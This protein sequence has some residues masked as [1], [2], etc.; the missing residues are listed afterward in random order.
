MKKLLI[1]AIFTIAVIGAIWFVYKSQSADDSSD[2]IVSAIE[3]VRGDAYVGYII[4]EQPVEGG[5]VVFFLRNATGNKAAS[6]VS[7]EYVKKTSSG[8]KWGY[9]GSFSAS[10]L[11]MTLPE[12]QAR[13]N[14][15]PIGNA[16]MYVPST[17]G[18]EFGDSPFPMLVGVV[19]HPDEVRVVVKDGVKGLERQ[20]ELIKVSDSFKLYYSFLD[21]VQ[22]QQLY[23]TTYNDNGDIVRED[24]IDETV[25]ITTTTNPE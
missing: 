24:I 8:W 16:S 1:S 18:S 22:G 21:E 10:N 19:V 20:A 2:S 3:K 13:D 6:A 9:G 4:H 25:T 17:A 23:I 11:H 14:P 12:Q 7:T 15:I 5:V